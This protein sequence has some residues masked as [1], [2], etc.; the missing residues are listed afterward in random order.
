MGLA[1]SHKAFVNCCEECHD[2]ATPVLQLLPPNFSTSRSDSPCTSSGN[3]S[4]TSPRAQEVPQPLPKTNR[5]RLALQEPQLPHIEVSPEHPCGL[6][7]HLGKLVE[8]SI[9]QKM[10]TQMHRRAGKRQLWGSGDY[11]AESDLL[12]ALIHS[13]YLKATCQEPRHGWKLPL[14]E[15]RAIVRVQEG[16]PPFQGT[17]SNGVCSRTWAGDF[18]GAS[19]RILRA[20]AVWCEVRLAS[21][22]TLFQSCSRERRSG[23]SARG[24]SG[25][26]CASAQSCL[27]TKASSARGPS[28]VRCASTQ[29]C[30]QTKASSVRGPSGARCAS[31]QSCPRSK[32]KLPSR[33]SCPRSKAALVPQ[34]PS[35]CARCGDRGG[36][37]ATRMCGLG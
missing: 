31:S 5:Q 22:L 35:L 37:R 28:G 13:G 23:S 33:Q 3:A 29:S 2:H 25:V 21:K 7:N 24:P 10:L 30:L 19:F 11:T 8:L 6:D 27:Q 17:L 4:R 26:R 36:C 20:W 18:Q 32:A 1:G 12:L 14:L 9:P 34:H 16:V 15:L